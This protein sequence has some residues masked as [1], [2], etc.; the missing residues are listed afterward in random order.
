MVKIPEEII[1]P[2]MV[3]GWGAYSVNNEPRPERI[4]QL[5]RKGWDFVP[6]ERHPELAFQGLGELDPRKSGYIWRGGLVLMERPIEYQELEYKRID[7]INYKM[8]VSAP[9][10]EGAA[11][12]VNS[13]TQYYQGPM[14]NYRNADFG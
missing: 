3:Y 2:G 14:D 11:Y 6:I 10:L 7:E 13:N 5:R 8:I 1:P 12:P 9:G 4:M